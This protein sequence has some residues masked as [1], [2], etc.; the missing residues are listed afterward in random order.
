MWLSSSAFSPKT[1]L[2]IF[3]FLII[4]KSTRSRVTSVHYIITLHFYIKLLILYFKQYDRSAKLIMVILSNPYM[5]IAHLS[6]IMKE[7]QSSCNNVTWKCLYY[8]AFMEREKK[9]FTFV[10]YVPQE[11]VYFRAGRY[12]GII[13]VLGYKC[14]IVTQY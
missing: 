11:V 14:F 3:F 6:F 8:F 7:L 4:I 5:Y 2:L 1:T 9:I 10:L 12:T 13:V